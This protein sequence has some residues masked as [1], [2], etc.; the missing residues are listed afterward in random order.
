[1]RTYFI[2][3]VVPRRLSFSG[4]RCFSTANPEFTS[5]ASAIH[6]RCPFRSGNSNGEKREQSNK[7]I[8]AGPPAHPGLPNLILHPPAACA[9]RRPPIFSAAADRLYVRSVR[10]PAPS[11]LLT[12]SALL[13]LLRPPFLAS[14][15]RSPVA[16]R[17]GQIALWKSDTTPAGLFDVKSDLITKI[18]VMITPNIRSWRCCWVLILA[19]NGGLAPGTVW[20]F[21]VFWQHNISFFFCLASLVELPLEFPPHPILHAIKL[22]GGGVQWCFYSLSRKCSRPNVVWLLQRCQGNPA[23]RKMMTY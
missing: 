13:D 23:D 9:T 21:T 5:R 2:A 12:P 11:C 4:Q 18:L 14:T 8:S 3:A 22:K 6:T 1:M 20:F 17:G 19:L 10:A 15:E 7:I 16:S